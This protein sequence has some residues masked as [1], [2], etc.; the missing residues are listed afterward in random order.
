MNVLFFKIFYFFGCGS[1][2]KCIE[3]VS[4]LLLFYVLVFWPQGNVGSYVPKQGLNLHSPHWEA[5]S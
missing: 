4:V 3:F 1:F 5:K 2:F